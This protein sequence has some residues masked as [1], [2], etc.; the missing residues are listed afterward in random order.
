MLAAERGFG[1][2][3]V[4]NQ[5]TAPANRFPQG[6]RVPLGGVRSA[7]QS[8][9]PPRQTAS[10]R[11]SYPAARGGAPVKDLRTLILIAVLMAI[12]AACSSPGTAPPTGPAGGQTIGSET[13]APTASD[14]GGYGY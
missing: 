5:H 6:N 4:E 11:G 2:G 13:P 9:A 14:S 10:R 8:R 12:L 1:K 3:G 7:G